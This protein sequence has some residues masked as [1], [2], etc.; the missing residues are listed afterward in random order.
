MKNSRLCRI[1]FWGA[2]FMLTGWLTGCAATYSK[3]EFGCAAPTGVSC[4]SISGLN[5]N[6]DAGNLPKAKKSVPT[7]DDAREDRDKRTSS[8]RGDDDV[9]TR[10][11]STRTTAKTNKD[12]S[13]IDSNA[14]IRIPPKQLRVWIAPY[15]DEH[16][17]F[18]DGRRIYVQIHDGRWDVANKKQQVRNQ[19]RTIQLLQGNNTNR[20]DGVENTASGVNRPTPILLEK[21]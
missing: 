5:A 1:P 2:L 10:G 9:P 18:M 15:Q 16:G 4:M 7:R 14:P 19:Y 3:S 21:Q 20:Q 8:A 6:I 13:G 11:V 17:N 12:E